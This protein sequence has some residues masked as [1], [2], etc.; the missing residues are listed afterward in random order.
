MRIALPTR[1]TEIDDHFGHCESYTIFTIGENNEITGSETIPS[2]TGCGCKSGIASVL[3]DKGVTVML[4]GNMG[5]GAVNVLANSG[6]SVYRGN[7]GNVAEIAQQFLK[8]GVSDSGKS[9]SH[10]HGDE[11]HSH[12]CSH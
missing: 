6:I 10:H 1:G 3:S 8:G 9:C 5:E 4:A 7:R 11:G 2:T 12:V